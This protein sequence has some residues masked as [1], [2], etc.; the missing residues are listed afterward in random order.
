MPLSPASSKPFYRDSFTFTE[1]GSSGTIDLTRNPLNSFSI[2]VKGTGASPTLWGVRFQGSLDGTNWTT[3]LNH[4]TVTGD[5]VAVSSGNNFMPMDYIRI[6]VNSL[7]LGSA[8][9]I[10]VRVLGMQ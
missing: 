7:T 9:N 4:S 10:I 2:S 3:L 8:T 1:T 6:N 5:G